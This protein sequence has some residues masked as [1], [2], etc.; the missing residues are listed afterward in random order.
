MTDRNAT[1]EAPRL[2]RD[3]HVTSPPRRVHVGRGTDGGNRPRSRRLGAGDRQGASRQRH[4]QRRGRLDMASALPRLRSPSLP[5]ASP[6]PT[7]AVASPRDR[8]QMLDYN[9]RVSST[10]AYVSPTR[11][12]RATR[13]K[14]RG[15]P[16]MCR[17]EHGDTSAARPPSRARASSTPSCSKRTRTTHTPHHPPHRTPSRRFV[18]SGT[19]VTVQW[20]PSACS[21]LDVLKGRFVQIAEDWRSSIRIYRS[22]DVERSARVDR[23]GHRSELAEVAGRATRGW[24]T[25]T[26]SNSSTN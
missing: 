8:G 22:P 18:Q 25:G 5:T 9:F 13:C 4:R 6:S 15:H 23:Q 2:V 12:A 10:E 20:P 24:R 7:T 17:V 14:W 19:R 26:T 16:P 21:Q 11:G 3:L 1:P